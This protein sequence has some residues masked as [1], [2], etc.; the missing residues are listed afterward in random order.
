MSILERLSDPELLGQMSLGQKLLGSL[1][2]AVIGMLVCM[3]VLAI[4]MLAIRIM[5]ALMSRKDAPA[6]G[7]A[8]APA[9]VPAAPALADGECGVASPCAGTV[10]TLNAFEGAAVREGDV[11]LLMEADGSVFQFPA[12]AEGTVARVCAAEGDAVSAGQVLVILR[13]KEGEGD[14]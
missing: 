4:I 6:E 5:H 13:E 7:P 1:I 11:L 14:D 10:Q 9:P 12:P 3:V 8:P 2:T